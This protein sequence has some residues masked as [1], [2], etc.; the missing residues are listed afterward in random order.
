MRPASETFQEVNSCD[1]ARDTATG[2]VFR[3]MLC[4][5]PCARGGVRARVASEPALLIRPPSPPYFAEIVATCAAAALTD[6]NE[7]RSHSTLAISH[8][9][10]SALTVASAASAR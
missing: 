2:G 4:A 6:S 8:D 7:S 3:A 10:D 1:G 5:M 9:P